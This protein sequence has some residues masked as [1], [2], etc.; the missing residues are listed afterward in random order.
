M[1]EGEDKTEDPTP[2]RISEA[3]EKGQVARST[4]LDSVVVLLAGFLSLYAFR[5]RLYGGLFDMTHLIF[6]ESMRTVL[7]AGNIC[8]YTQAGILWMLKLLWPILLILLVAGFAVSYLQI[9]WLFTL[10][11]LLPDFSKLNPLNGVKNLISMSKLFDVVKE[12]IKLI[13]IGVVA[14]LTIKKEMLLYFTLVDHSPE[15]ILIV[16]FGSLFKLGMRIALMLLLLALIDFLYQRWRYKDQMKMSKQ[17]VKDERKQSEGDPL[18]KGKIKSLQIEM[19]MRRMMSQVPKA[20]VVVTNPTHLAIALRYEMGVDKAPVVLAKGKRK[21]AERIKEI[22]REHQ[23][24][25]V[26]DKP[27]ARAM[28][29]IIE[30]GMEIPKE[31]FTPVAEI[32]AYVY[33]LKEKVA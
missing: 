9:G 8:F 6:Q 7:T 13:I 1:A 29:D 15:Q 31:F 28:I 2:K 22:A 20:T 30:I 26:E 11:P 14:Y 19:A 21:T 5:E 24:P 17:E 27:L 32:L 33:K 25:I 12:S 3:R 23:I 4:E 10:K 18:V 16:I